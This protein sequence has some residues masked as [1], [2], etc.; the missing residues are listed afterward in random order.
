MEPIIRLGIFAIVFIAAAAAE[1][2]APR[3]P[4][5]PGTRWPRWR[6]NLGLGLLNVLAQ[7]LL[8]GAAALSAAIAAAGHGWGLLNQLQLPLW[9]EAAAGI[10]ILDAAVFGQ[11][12]ATHVVPL[13][14]RFHRV[15]H[16]DTEVDVSTG[17]RFHPVEILLSLLYKALV[18]V[19]AGADPAVVIAYEVLLSA[20]TLFTHAN[21]RLPQGLDE[22][23]RLVICTPDMHR[24]HHSCLAAETDSNYG[25]ILSCWDRLAGTYFEAP[26]AGHGSVVLGLADLRDAQALTMAHL[27]REPFR[28]R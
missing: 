5:E 25:N 17:L 6:T 26:A 28:H 16:S 23:L 7:R 19:L 10:I 22:K 2:V 11:H 8:L 9:L 24:R 1:A 18:V 21:I 20:A 13:F 27:L 12:V 3:R 15:H 4:A 14:W